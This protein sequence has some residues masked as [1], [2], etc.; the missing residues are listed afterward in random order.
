[1][2][3]SATV[4]W[5]PISSFGNGVGEAEQPS[6][7]GLFS[8]IFKIYIHCDDILIDITFHTH[9]NWNLKYNHGGFAFS[10]FRYVY[11]WTVDD[12]DSIIC[13]VYHIHVHVGLENM[14]GYIH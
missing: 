1:M 9:Y 3:C 12:F 11:E 6:H 4:E 13:S 8:S 2:G 14:C 5:N 10:H 7:H